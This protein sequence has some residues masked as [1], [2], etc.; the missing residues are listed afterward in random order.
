MTALFT[1]VS[2][3]T[4]TAGYKVVELPA[5]EEI[6]TELARIM[7][8][9]DVVGFWIS[10]DHRNKTMSPDRRGRSRIEAYFQYL[11]GRKDWTFWNIHTRVSEASLACRQRIFALNS[12]VSD[13]NSSKW[14]FANPNN[15]RSFD[16]S[17]LNHDQ[18]PALQWIRCMY[19][20]MVPHISEPSVAEELRG[21]YSWFS[22]W[23]L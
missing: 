23:I 19:S 6:R 15:P 9:N 5:T 21:I 12:L 10:R 16:T 7:W 4:P 3:S 14:S 18:P 20:T 11:K 1:A 2:S 17:K 22:K 8:F 13:W